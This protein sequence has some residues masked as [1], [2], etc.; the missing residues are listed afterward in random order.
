MV[1]AAV[2]FLRGG[3]PFLEDDF[4]WL[5]AA[6]DGLFFLLDAVAV[7]CC[8][9]GVDEVSWAGNPLPCR[10]SNAV[11]LM[12]VNR[13]RILTGFSVTRLCFAAAADKR[14]RFRFLPSRSDHE[15]PT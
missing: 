12:A 11:R 9:V 13:L 8:F 15:L 7:L 1:R 2:A 14:C 10:S 6:D 4:F 5:D 3:W